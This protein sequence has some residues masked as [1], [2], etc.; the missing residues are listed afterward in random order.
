MGKVKNEKSKIKGIT[1]TD[2]ILEDKA[3]RPLG[4]KKEKPNLHDSDEEVSL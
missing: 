3:V 1:L 4:R 2:Q